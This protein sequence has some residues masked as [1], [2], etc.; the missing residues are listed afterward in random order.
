MTATKPKG[1]MKKQDNNKKKNRQIEVNPQRDSLL[2]QRIK[3]L[4]FKVS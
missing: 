1:K 3:S 4:L 2:V